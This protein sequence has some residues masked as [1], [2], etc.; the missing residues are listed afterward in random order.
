MF[1]KYTRTKNAKSSFDLDDFLKKV[2]TKRFEKIKRETEMARCFYTEKKPK[3]QI[4]R[5]YGYKTTT[6]IYRILRE[7]YVPPHIAQNISGEKNVH[8]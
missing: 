7:Y 6:P 4:A 1:E 3:I 2:E 8:E 5:E